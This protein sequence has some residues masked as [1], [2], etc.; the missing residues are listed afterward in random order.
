MRKEKSGKTV[1]LKDVI[2]GEDGM[3]LNYDQNFS[4]KGENI[5]E[6]ITT[7]ERMINYNNLF[8]KAG[9]PVIKNF[10]VLKKFGT[11]HD[12]STD[13]FNEEIS[14]LESAK[15]QNEKIEEINELGNFFLLEEESIKKTEYVT[16][17]TKNKT[18]ANQIVRIQK[19][20]QECNKAV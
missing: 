13:L 6:K 4:D 7:D 5:L 17:K 18:Q 15:K 20:M 8:F 16:K 1:L 10:D 3:L 19:R 2:Y 12:L 9:D 11:L 14:T